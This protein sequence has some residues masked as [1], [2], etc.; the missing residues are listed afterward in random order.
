MTRIA[1]FLALAATLV[2]LPALA[3]DKAAPLGF[4]AGTDLAYSSDTDDTEVVTAGIDIDAVRRPNTQYVGIRLEKAWFDPIH[5]GWRSQ[6]RA[7]LRAASPLGAWQGQAE[8]GTD[9][10]TVIGAL[11]VNDHSPFRKELFVERSIVETRQGLD[12]GL[13]QTFV[14][15]AIDL[16]VD[17]RNSFNLLVGAQAF[18][19]RNERLHLRGSYIHVLAPRLGL[20][21][22]LRA[23]YFS[24][25]VPGEFDY[26]SPRRHV[27]VLPVL[28]VRR[29]LDSWELLG[30][31]GIG[32][33]RD[34][35]ADWRQ[36]RYAQ[37]RV[38]KSIDR[39]GWGVTGSFTYTNS[40]ADSGVGDTGYSY[41][42]FT[43]G[44]SRRF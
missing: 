8:I 11:S 1:K 37:L 41:R 35:S 34:A 15:A 2:P 18:T 29:F 5:S 4:V 30:V 44:I 14:G 7:Y 20:S 9:G 26:Y 10:A 39:D 43:L 17:A 19:G 32:A 22:Q 42:Q 28:Q 36:L 40:P 24:S 13:Y 21:V 12:R 6:E 27:E 31:G 16:P 23:R 38:R 3:Q 33:Q 25:S